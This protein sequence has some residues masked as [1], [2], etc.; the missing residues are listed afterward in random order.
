MFISFVFK[1][2]DLTPGVRPLPASGPTGPSRTRTPPVSHAHESLHIHFWLHVEIKRQEK[3]FPPV[4]KGNCLQTPGFTLR[5][6]GLGVAGKHG[7]PLSKCKA[8]ALGESS[9]PYC[10]HRVPFAHPSIIITKG[11]WQPAAEAVKSKSSL[12]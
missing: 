4:E 8:A 11:C 7:H 2:S 10:W 9:E 6:T 12:C 1:V 3:S 5:A